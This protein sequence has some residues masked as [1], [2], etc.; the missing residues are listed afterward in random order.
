MTLAVGLAGGL[1][2]PL[3]YPAVARNARP[4][5]KRT[6]KAGIAVFERAKVAAAELGEQASDLMAEVRAENAEDL[7]G[8]SATP[9]PKPPGDVVRFHGAGGDEASG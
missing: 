9:G 4:I 5:A 3:L 1:I 7:N 8:A 2:A 6:V